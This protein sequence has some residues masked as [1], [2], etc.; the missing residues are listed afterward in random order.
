M[1]IIKLNES[2]STW[3]KLNYKARPHQNFKLDWSAYYS[4]DYANSFLPFIENN[5]HGLAL[6]MFDGAELFNTLEITE[7]KYLH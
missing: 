6:W 4:L 3:E 7:K 1:K 5:Y 2:M